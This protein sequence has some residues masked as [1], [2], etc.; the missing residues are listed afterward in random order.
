MRLLLAAEPVEVTVPTPTG[1]GFGSTLHVVI[2]AAAQLPGF[3]SVVPARPHL[4]GWSHLL[5]FVAAL[6]LCPLAIVFSPGQRLSIGLFSGAVIALF[7]ISAA[8]HVL[9]WGTRAEGIFRRLD[10][11]MIFITI[12][13]TYTPIVVVAIP[14]A[15]QLTLLAVVWVGALAGATGQLVSSKSP[16]WLN[17]G[18]YVLIGWSIL[19]AIN[20]VWASLG[21][22][23]FV[24]LA[25]GGLLHTVGALIYATNRPNPSPK[26]FGFHEVFHLF[27]VAAVASHYVL[28]AI[29]L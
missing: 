1:S 20:Y 14:R 21:V 5:A 23:G 4:R 28:I 8:Y 13:A 19:P 22:A 18:L 3:P 15:G 29:L 17:V 7:G 16:R 10:H 24:L 27:V 9:F 25:T 26:W 6:T 2:T 11:A 12:A